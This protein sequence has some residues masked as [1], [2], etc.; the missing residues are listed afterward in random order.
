MPSIS[1]PAASSCKSRR[2]HG[3]LS[4]Y[5]VIHGVETV[6]AVSPEEIRALEAYFREDLQDLL[7]EKATSQSVSPKQS[8][9]PARRAGD[10]RAVALAGVVQIVDHERVRRKGGKELAATRTDRGSGDG[11]G[12]GRVRR[13]GERGGKQQGR[14]SDRDGQDARAVARMH[15]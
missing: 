14:G 8:A 1:L 6:R 4:G 12:G 9:E 5:V 11:A 3:D 15:G 10:A 7:D 13:A 2:R